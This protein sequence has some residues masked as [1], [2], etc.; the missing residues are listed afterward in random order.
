MKL[1]ELL[2]TDILHITDIWL[3]GLEHHDKIKAVARQLNSPRNTV[4]RVD[5]NQ[6]WECTIFFGK[7]A[8]YNNIKYKWADR[9]YKKYGWGNTTHL[10]KHKRV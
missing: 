8:S 9:L 3:V 10:V 6:V 4:L 5:A 7:F 2:L 1:F